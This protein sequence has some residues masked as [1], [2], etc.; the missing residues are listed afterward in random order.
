MKNKRI[1][2]VDDDIRNVFAISSILEEK[3][4]F[5]IA[6]KDGLEALESLNTS[7][8]ID[9]VLM[10]IMMPVMD[11]YKTMKEIRKQERFKDL[12]IIAFTAKAMRGDKKFCLEAG[13][14]DYLSKPIDID[15]LL[16]ALRVWLYNKR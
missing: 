11:G 3:G 4:M 15:K 12:P 6:A 16:S 14:N 9:L 1:L 8:D 13:A 10:D 7:P 2:L 5:I